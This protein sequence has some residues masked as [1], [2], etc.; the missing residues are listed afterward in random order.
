MTPA[1]AE[2]NPRVFP[3]ALKYT[4]R[5]NPIRLVAMTKRC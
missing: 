2:R 1:L 5:K 3:C 4:A